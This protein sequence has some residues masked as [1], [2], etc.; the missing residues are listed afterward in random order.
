MT[1]IHHAG[2]GGSPEDGGAER[3]RTDAVRPQA[4]SLPQR[5]VYWLTLVLGHALRWTIMGRRDPAR[6]RVS[7]RALATLTGR[8]QP[9]FG[10]PAQVAVQPR[11]DDRLRR[12]PQSHFRAGPS[13][14]T[15]GGTQM[16]TLVTGGAGFIGSHVVRALLDG[17]RGRRP[18]LRSRSRSTAD[19]TPAIPRTSFI[20][21]D[22]GDRARPPR[23]GRGRRVVHLA[24]V[25]A[26]GSRCTRS[27]ATRARTRWP[28]RPSSS[29]SWRGR[30][31]RAGS[32]SRPRCRSTARAST[33]A[34]PR[35]GRPGPAARG[36]AAR[37]T[38]GGLVPPLR[39][40][41]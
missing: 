25:S 37:P 30:S 13:P 29:R 8:A 1:I 21:G 5:A 32:S 15:T 7:Q 11:A 3:V 28:P 24:A 38:V 4:F 40:A 27:I 12:S 35:C 34:R 20:H 6:K 23:A 14:S 31:R 19:T 41:T 36:A 22:V 17:R 16:K 9:P 26:S 2:K 18:R 39:S 33:S 10:D